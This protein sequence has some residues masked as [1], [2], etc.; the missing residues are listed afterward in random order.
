MDFISTVER[1]PP[2]KQRRKITIHDNGIGYYASFDEFEQL[3]LFASTLGFTYELFE[4]KEHSEYIVYRYFKMSHNIASE[5]FRKLEE[6]PINAK[7]IISLSNGSLVTCYYLNDGE[8]ITIYRPNPND[9]DIY[10]PLEISEHISHIKT[11][12]SY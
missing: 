2:Y 6:I 1:I 3:E 9:K 10:K 7:P 12:G 4:E 11:Y 5:L 8:K